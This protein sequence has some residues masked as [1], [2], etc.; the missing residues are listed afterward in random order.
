[1]V[2]GEN[3]AMKPQTV[4]Q[5]LAALPAPT[6]RVMKQL[7]ALIREAA[8]DATETLSYGMPTFVLHG[9]LVHDAGY[10]EHVG[11]YGARAMKLEGTLAKYQT[12]KGTLRFELDTT[13]PAKVIAQLVTMR[14]AE[15]LEKAASKK[16]A[17]RAK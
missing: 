17:L 1:M 2:A 8:P 16:K 10:A 13:L 3:A 15:N 9:N 5:Y 12:G 14:V 6:R 11:L 7:R 4:E